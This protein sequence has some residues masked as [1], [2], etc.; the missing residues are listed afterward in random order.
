MMKTKHNRSAGETEI[1]TFRLLKTINLHIQ[2]VKKTKLSSLENRAISYEVCHIDGCLI[3]VPCT[4]F[5]LVV[6][7]SVLGTIGARK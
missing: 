5:Y 6:M 2:K 4:F 7:G 3:H 1:H